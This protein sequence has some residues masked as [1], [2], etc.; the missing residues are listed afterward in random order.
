M[1]TG[2]MVRCNR[3][4]HLLQHGLEIVSTGGKT[5]LAAL[6]AAVSKVTQARQSVDR[7]SLTIQPWSTHSTPHRPPPCYFCTCQWPPECTAQL[8]RYSGS[9]WATTATRSWRRVSDSSI[10]GVS[11]ATSS[12]DVSGYIRTADL[13]RKYHLTSSVRIGR[14]LLMSFV[15]GRYS[16]LWNPRTSSLMPLDFD[17]ACVTRVE[18]W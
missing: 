11:V 1:T 6:Q 12:T 9:G 15:P 7:M 16:I 10:N 3:P 5:Q 13:V 2:G 8:G 18:G 14:I 4:L 17:G